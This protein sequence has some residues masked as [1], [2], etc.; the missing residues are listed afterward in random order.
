MTEK[1][2]EMPKMMEIE[3]AFSSVP[4][5]EETALSVGR[6]SGDRY[7]LFHGKET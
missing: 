1:H 7:I 6:R 3:I 5:V 4:N 2:K